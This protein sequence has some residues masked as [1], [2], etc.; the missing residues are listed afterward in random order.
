[1][2]NLLRWG[3]NRWPLEYKASVFTIPPR[4]R[5]SVRPVLK[6]KGWGPIMSNFWGRFFHVFEVNFFSFFFWKHYR[7]RTKKL[8][9]TFFTKKF[10]KKILTPKTWKNSFFLGLRRFSNLNVLH[11]G[12]LMQDWVFRLGQPPWVL[13]HR[14]TACKIHVELC[15]LH[16]MALLLRRRKTDEGMKYAI[17]W[18]AQF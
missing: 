2:K 17:M 4:N 14:E 11:K 9:D 5:S 13:P 15:S 8:H 1:M 6:K 12:L 16:D 10:K 7:V 18:W 3:S